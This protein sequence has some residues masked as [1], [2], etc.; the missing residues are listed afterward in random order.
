MTMR[1]TTLSS[2]GLGTFDDSYNGLTSTSSWAGAR[3]TATSL[4][5]IRSDSVSSS[6]FGVY[7]RYVS[8]RGVNTYYNYRSYFTWNLSSIIGVVASV[9]VRMYL[10]NLGTTGSPAQ[11]VPVKATLI[12]GGNE[13]Y[14]NCF[15]SGLTLGTKL[16]TQQEVSTTAGFHFFVFNA[17]GVREVAALVGTP[18]AFSLG[19]MSYG[20]DYRGSPVPSLGGDYTKIKVYYDEAGGNGPLMSIVHEPPSAIFMGHNF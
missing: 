20:A 9:E 13:D 12:E 8:A 11:I 5:T 19:F 15:S 18:T 17:D 10:D 16:A 2:Y 7:S 1:T 4:S 3:G 14:G 6:D